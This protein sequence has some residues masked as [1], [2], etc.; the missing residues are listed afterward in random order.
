MKYCLPSVLL[1]CIFVQSEAHPPATATPSSAA[2]APSTTQTPAYHESPPDGPLPPTLDPS[3]FKDNSIA[4]VAYTLAARIEAV[5]YQVPCHCPCNKEQGHKS[6][7]DCFTSRHGISCRTCQQEAIFCFTQH[8]KGKKPADIRKGI[9]DGKAWK[10]DLA[11]YAKRFE[12][13]PQSQTDAR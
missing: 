11:S 8:A 2:Q 12:L 10:V 7:L 6:L 3:Q 4:R 5:L 9:A 1:L 13:Q